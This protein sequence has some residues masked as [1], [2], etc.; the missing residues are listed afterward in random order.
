MSKDVLKMN[1]MYSNSKVLQSNWLYSIFN[2]PKIKLSCDNK[3]YRECVVGWEDQTLH[4]GEVL[5]GST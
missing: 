5:L 1:D 3:I 2:Y 4:E